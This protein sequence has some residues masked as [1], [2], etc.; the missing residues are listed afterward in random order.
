M[1]EFICDNISKVYEDFRIEDISFK[2][3]AGYVLGI[4]GRNGCG[5]ST[6]IKALL[7]WFPKS[8]GDSYIGDKSLKN[9]GKD[10][11]LEIAYVLNECP[12]DATYTA[13][14]IGLT[15]GKYYKGFDMKKYDKL[16]E[17]FGLSKRKWISNL[18]QGQQIRLQLAFAMSYQA[19][20]YIF[21]EPAG[22]LDIEFRNEFYGYVREIM[23]DSS[24]SVICSSHLIE[25]LEEISDYILWL[26][27][28][29]NITKIYYYGTAEE[30]K[31]SYRMLE[32]D[33]DLA[34]EI[35][36]LAKK[37]NKTCGGRRRDTHSELLVDKTLLEFKEAQELIN[38]KCSVRYA[39]LKEI[40]Y[41]LEKGEL[42]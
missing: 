40:M 17:K 25:E 27:R 10:Y 22:N 12:F 21:D 16:L 42:V 20:V 33:A 31:E 8:E 3:P 30:L 41:Y 36:G 35:K 18:S 15:Y 26:R 13:K 11:K 23:E 37:Y 28:D 6:L 9:N 32:C 5:K 7:G 1:S 29:N 39:D 2:L 38:S 34:V 4:I 14:Q 24:K 19:T